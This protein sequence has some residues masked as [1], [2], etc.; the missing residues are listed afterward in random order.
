[1]NY[2]IVRKDPLKFYEQVFNQEITRHRV[3]EDKE[4]KRQQEEENLKR[5][6]DGSPMVKTRVPVT[7][8]TKVTKRP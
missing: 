4:L 5:E 1:M 7:I 6:R 2:D 8:Q 3:G